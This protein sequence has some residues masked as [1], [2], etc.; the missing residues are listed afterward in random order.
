[1]S[2]L[3]CVVEKLF[4]DKRSLFDG[5]S[6][7]A[8]IYSNIVSTVKDTRLAMSAAFEVLEAS[9]AGAS[10]GGP[11]SSGGPKASMSFRKNGLHHYR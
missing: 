9:S 10:S 3:T 2:V 7:T 4:I 8:H 1:M 6:K 5:K 11:V